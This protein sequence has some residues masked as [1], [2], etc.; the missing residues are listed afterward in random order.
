MKKKSLAFNA[1]LSSLN[2][3]V[4]IIFPLITFPYI[5]RV[6]KADN[7][8]IYNFGHSIIEYFI[9]LASFGISAYAIRNG[10]S[11]RDDKE[12]L[13]VFA[14]KMFTL[15][16]ITTVISTGL[17]IG[18][19]FLPTKLQNY[20]YI[21]LI[22]AVTLIMNPFILDWFYSIFEDFTYITVRNIAVKIISL[23]LIFLFVRKETDVF[24]YTWIV[25]LSN[26]VAYGFNFV[27]SRKYLKLKVTR[28]CEFANNIKV[29]WI[30]FA[31]SLASTI[32]LNSDKTL[33]G[34]L[35]DD[36]TVGIYSV[37]A[38]IY[39]ITK[40]LVNAGVLAI[41]PRMSYYAANQEDAFKNL[42]EKILRIVIFIGM[43][44]SAG[45]MILSNEAV[46]LI[47]GDGYEG[48]D[49]ALLI[50]SFSL[51]FA[52]V[53][54]VFANG[55]LL[56]FRKEKLVVRCTAI[57]AVANLV[58]NLFMIPLWKHNGA[59]ITTLIAEIIML[60][61]SVYYSRNDLKGIRLKGTIAHSVIATVAMTAIG[62]L[63]RNAAIHQHYL[64]RILIIVACCAFS[65][66][67]IQIL[68]KEEV[69]INGYSWIKKRL[70]K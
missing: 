1:G 12:K 58:L 20:S 55:I 6:L 2:Q 22:H 31:N 65:Y 41:I 50:L 35:C 25:S 60:S 24:L 45:L 42:T 59:A 16:I 3:L 43:P 49:V 34:L 39:Y 27:H 64:V 61:M 21:I 66:F 4:S 68:F 38:N 33:L 51:I 28:N 9:L 54:N 29:L 69:V 13:S 5:S 7:I 56:S 44:L 26:A 11:I 57:S 18:I 8:G 67:G 47:S 70:K 63:I 30:F 52:I 40:K 62:L 48:A 17:L 19:L 53:S 23:I 10:S 36:R 14:S 46:L 32:Y 15:N 37:A